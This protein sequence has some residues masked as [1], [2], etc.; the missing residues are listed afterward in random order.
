MQAR[1]GNNFRVVLLGAAILAGL[2]LV[3]PALAQEEQPAET[4]FKEEVEVTGTLIPRPTL[5]A[6]SPVT[7]LEIEELS[8]RGLTRIEDLLTALPQIFAAQ[9]STIA[10]GATG[11]ATVDLR[12][13]GTVRTLVLI[14]GQRMSSGD[15]WDTA[16]DLNFIPSALVKRVDILTGGA[17]S[18]YG[19]DAVAGVVN[20]ILDKD[21]EGFRGG[22]QFGG[23]QHT[24][25]NK[26][27]RSMNAARGFKVPEGDAWDG[28]ALNANIALG[29]KFADGKGHASAYLDYRK[30]SAVRKD[31]R[32]YTNCAPGLGTN[33]PICS[34]SST[35][36]L[37][38][39][40]VFDRDYNFMGDYTLDQSGPGN[41]FR[42]RTAMDVFNYAPYNFMQRPAEKYTGGGFLNYDWN[43]HFEAYAS[44]MFMDDYT[45]AQIAPSGNFG[46]TSLIN[47]DNPMLSPQQRQRLCTDAGYGPTDMANVTILRRNVEGGA[48]VAQL[49]HTAFRMVTGLKGEINDAWSYN[50]FGLHAEV[51]SPQSYKNDLNVIR[52][53]DALI[54]DG[55]PN[56]P[57]T[58]H[59]R[60]GNPGC[61]PWN[62]FKIGGVT[63][64]AL[65]YL[66]IPL[67]LDSGTK[68]EMLGARFTGDMKEY[69][70]ALPSAT[71]G[72][73]L[74]LG[75][76]YRKEFL[77]VNPDLAY[78]EGWGS[79][80]GGPTVPV[81]GSY[82]V[83]E[84]FLEA[85]VP[86]VQGAPAAKD[87]SL[88]LGYRYSKYN[89]SGNH[90]TWKA[91]LG[92]SPSSD[93]KVRGGANRA[94]RAP[95]VRELFTP[96]GLGL[97]GSQ[98]ICAGPNPTAT[99]EQ[100]R[101]TG[102]TPAQYGNILPNPAEQYNTLGGGNPNLSPEVADTLTAGIV[103]TPSAVSG[104]SMAFDYFDIDIDKTIGSLGADDIINACANTGD[105]RLCSLIH[106]DRAGTLW[107]TPDGYTITTNQN[108]GK[109]NVQ[110]L[111]ANLSYLMPI[112][113]SLFTINM[114]GSYLQ[115]Q[116]IDS[117]LYTYDCVGYFGNQCG[118]PSPKWRH[119]SRFGW[120]TG[121]ISVSL[122]WRYIHAVTNDDGSPNPAL[123]DPGNVARLQRNGIYKIP[124]HHYFDLAASYKIGGAIQL[125]LGVNNIADKEPP[126]APGMQD[127][128]YG[129]GFYGT[130][131]PYGRYVHT[132]LQFTF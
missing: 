50:V 63:K 128:D 108:I 20:F 17:S 33:G 9:N 53:Q 86:L 83:K 71:E 30:T 82:D 125:I 54:V 110:G 96:Q 95:N 7:T 6:L 15:A 107:L 27:A 79:G 106:R 31:R 100:C 52:L 127:N 69:G 38:R 104:L 24:N 84:A 124:A 111:D 114:I 32:D 89:T 64:D 75:T 115:K 123:G 45:D 117:G 122:G 126:L 93:F 101:R 25:D 129:P 121:N 5:E 61:V 36:P 12:Y 112:G 70:W 42:N 98:D 85:L 13:L 103:I 74:A 105:P 67:V 119:L 34:G 68:T 131:D 81:S 18:V 76:E 46:N 132:A 90:P 72:I 113:K 73:Q 43:R 44:I 59:C 116:A 57:S 40:I 14:D 23:F 102:V 55:D 118:I 2:G 80:Q 8:Y 62:I 1:S 16:P 88:E 51:R 37:G 94:T 26:L 58:W 56:D 22:I 66:S 3:I 47:C 97:G 35:I 60:S 92:W 41:T 29:G 10:N 21:F 49:R 19:A 120:E 99:L 65:D 87:L 39:F 109:R 78:R 130:Y 48:R 11:T 4:K 91:Q 77:F 28:G